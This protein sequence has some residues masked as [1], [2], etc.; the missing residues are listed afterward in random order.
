MCINN[1]NP[2]RFFGA[3]EGNIYLTEFP[4]PNRGRLTYREREKCKLLYGF[5][6]NCVLD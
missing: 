3:S 6:L 5:V 4:D 2:K 1:V